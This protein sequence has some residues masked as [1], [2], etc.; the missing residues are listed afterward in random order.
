VADGQPDFVEA[1]TEQVREAVA[2]AQQTV[3]RSEFLTAASRLVREPRGM[4]KRCAW[5]GRFGMARRWMRPEQAPEFLIARVETRATHT[6]CP[7]CVRQL[8]ETGKS[9]R[10]PR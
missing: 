2:R 1:L 5:C 9:H 8:E 6:I 10:T 3:A 4:I 7:D